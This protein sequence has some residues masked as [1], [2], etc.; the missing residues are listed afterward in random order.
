MRYRKGSQRPDVQKATR[1]VDMKYEELN[2][3]VFDNIRD[4]NPV[5]TFECGQVF[6]W[7]PEEEKGE[8]YAG[9]AGCNAARIKF[10]DGKLTIEASGGDQEFWYD[11]FDLTTD[12]G[13]IKDELVR[14]EPKIEKACEYGYGI[15]ILRQD[16][17]ETIISFIISQNNNIPR[18]RKNIESLCETYGE[19]IGDIE[20]K[21]VYA[22]PTPEALADADEEE[23]SELK[24]GYRG[25]YIIETAKKYLEAGCPTCREELLSMHGVGPKVANCIML[26]G[27]SD[28]AAFPIDTWV[29]QIMTDMY[30]FADKD[31]KGMQRFAEEKFGSY[32]GYA[33]QY[34]FYY[35][36]DRS[37]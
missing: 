7:R 27:L 33:Q 30:G 6:R 29:R 3:I 19:E 35:Y 22:F 15:R 11:Y 4:F 20:G 24:L 34:L 26:F 9:V 18:I 2:N 32:A 37:L 16:L 8:I 31:V 17:F 25:P 14:N 13:A 12:Y 36:R 10:S 21:T 1:S 23:L 5:H 28:V